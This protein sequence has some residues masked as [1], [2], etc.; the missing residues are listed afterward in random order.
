MQ[1]LDIRGST[2]VHRMD[3]KAGRHYLD[4]SWLPQSKYIFLGEAG[5]DHR[6][7]V[8]RGGQGRN[9]VSSKCRRVGG[10]LGGMVGHSPAYHS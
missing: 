8:Q 3:E 10:S 9:P 7:A 5:R 6:G 2:I 1:I 4:P